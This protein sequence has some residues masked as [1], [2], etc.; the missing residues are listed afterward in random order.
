[1]PGR[2]RPIELCG[3]VGPAARSQAPR[4]G[5]QCA[6]GGAGARSVWGW[7]SDGRPRHGGEVGPARRTERARPA[8]GTGCSRRWDAEPGGGWRTRRRR[9]R[10]RSRST[11]PSTGSA[12]GSGSAWLRPSRRRRWRR[13]CRT[14]RRRNPSTSSRSSGTSFRIRPPPWRSS[15]RVSTVRGLGN[16]QQGR[17]EAGG[18][19]ARWARGP[20]RGG[21]GRRAAAEPPG[22]GGAR[23]GTKGPRR[24]RE[25]CRPAATL[26]DGRENKMARGRGSRGRGP[27]S[28]RRGLRGGSCAGPAA[29]PPPAAGALG[30]ERGR[31]VSGRSGGGRAGRLRAAGASPER[32]GG[33]GG[34]GSP[35]LPAAPD[36]QPR[37]ETPDKMA[38]RGRAHCAPGPGRGRPGAPRRAG[39]TAPAAPAGPL[40]ARPAR[41]RSGAASGRWNKMAKPNM[42]VRSG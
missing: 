6:R 40:P 15:T 41:P 21:W 30:P 23:S 25:R 10:R 7:R 2:W 1:M 5:S 38:K 17:L 35:A 11:G 27:D 42:A 34:P 18:A 32:R 33:W 24:R 29:P 36:A 12:S 20:A 37:E 8:V 31:G 26:G 39:G 22:W 3:R 14:R 9:A 28:A 4:P 19:R 13:S 16:A